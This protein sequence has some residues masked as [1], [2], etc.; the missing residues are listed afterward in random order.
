MLCCFVSIGTED[1]S[2]EQKSDTTKCMFQEDSF[3]GAAVQLGQMRNM[4]RKRLLQKQLVQV[5][6]GRV[7]HQILRKKV[8]GP[9]RSVG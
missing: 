7:R 5:T 6:D 3:G 9:W 8:D 1:E 4:E 2:F